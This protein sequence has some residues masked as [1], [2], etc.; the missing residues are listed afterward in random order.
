MDIG[1]VKKHKIKSILPLSDTIIMET[2]I[3]GSAYVRD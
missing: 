1:Q 3:R 2:E